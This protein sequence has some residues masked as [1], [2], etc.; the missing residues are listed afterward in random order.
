M[1]ENERTLYENLEYLNETKGIIKQAIIDKGVEVSADTPFREYAD[2]IG[3]IQGGSGDL[4]DVITAQEQYIA[5]LEA[6][7]DEKAYV[8]S[9]TE[10]N[11]FVQ[12][13]EPT[14]KDGI[15]L[16][17]E[18]LVEYYSFE[19]E[20]FDSVGWSSSTYTPIPYE[21]SAG[22]I[23]KVG[24][25]IYLFG[26]SYPGSN[27]D[28]PNLHIVYK[29]DIQNDTYTRLTD[30]PIEI[31]HIS[32]VAY[33]TDIYIISNATGTGSISCITNYKYDTLTDTY[34]R[35]TDLPVQMFF[36]GVA[37]IEDNIYF[38]GG[39]KNPTKAYKYNI[40]TDTYTKLTDVPYS[41]S[42][43]NR[44][45]VAVG[46]FIYLLGGGATTSSESKYN[47]KYDTLTDTYTKLTDLP[48]A[49]YDGAAVSIGTDIYIIGGSSSGTSFY[50][51]DTVN[52][53]Y[54][55]LT[56]VPYSAFYEVGVVVGTDIHLFGGFNNFYI[57][58][59]Y[60][61]ASKQFENNTVVVNQGKFQSGS[62][63]VVLFY[64]DKDITSPKYSVK[65]AYF[66]TIENGLDDTI[67]T[68]YG[69]GTQ[70]VKFKN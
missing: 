27:Q 48:Y 4:D 20:I 18:K 19:N 17:I 23:V 7:I 40:T 42:R 66:Y 67:P 21:F 6:I 11:I 29:Y 60:S 43:L 51:Y 8:R 63:D 38:F 37:I 3:D 2:K 1:E 9:S 41:A 70:W 34:T 52:N 24:D 12:I 5:E 56:N 55:K 30:A 57:K 59:V 36:N 49:F 69:D 28:Y 15:W 10:P 61:L 44:Q 53:L 13:T 35:L 65:D 68:Y 62:Y 47:Y 16:Q 26:S 31:A 54:T 14:Q 39:T 46:N 33:G 58:K 50:K 32:A 25:F 45:C 22:A 64:N